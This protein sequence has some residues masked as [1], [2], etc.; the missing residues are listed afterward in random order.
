MYSPKEQLIKSYEIYAYTRGL[1]STIENDLIRSIKKQEVT[2]PAFRTLWIL[3]FEKN[4]TMTNL[5]FIAQTNISN[6]FRQVVKLKEQGLIQIENGKD[7]RT[8]ILTLT[9]SGKKIIDEF[10]DQHVA[11]S[12]LK[13]V[14]VLEKIS[15]QD[16][17]KFM[18]VASILSTELIGQDYTKWVTKSTKFILEEK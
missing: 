2:F 6:A 12:D 9:Q 10:I 3:Y 14:K 5:N 13:I 17:Q 7:T 11:N 8:K 16:L 15:P 18:K 1:N 4:M